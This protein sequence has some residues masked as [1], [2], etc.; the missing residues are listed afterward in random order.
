MM[1]IFQHVALSSNMWYFA[2][3]AALRNCASEMKILHLA[4][5]CHE[6]GNG[7]VSVAVDLACQHAAAG[8]SVGFAS[9]TGSFLGLLKNCGVE[10][11]AVDLDWTRPLASAKGFFALRRI[12]NLNQPDIV[13]AHAVPGA[14]FA[15]C[16]RSR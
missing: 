16:L 13:H 7:V 3:G 15:Y 11:F 9:A 4:P 5:H 8:H 6:D 12:I 10:H 2:R 1:P 14:L